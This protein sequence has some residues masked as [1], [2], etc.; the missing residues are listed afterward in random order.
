MGFDMDATEASEISQAVLPA[1]IREATNRFVDRLPDPTPLQ[2]S[3]R[4]GCWL[5]RDDSGE[6]GTHKS[7]GLMV[8]MAVEMH[9]GCS[10]FSISS[11][12]NAALAAAKWSRRL[13]A[14]CLC[15]LSHK[16]PTAKIEAVARTGAPTVVTSKPKNLSRYA[17][18]YAGLI[19]L[20]PSRHPLGAMGYRSLAA[21][22]CVAR[23]RVSSVFC[24]CNSG[25][26][27]AG[28]REG[29]DLLLAAGSIDSVPQLHAVQC[30]ERGDLPTRLG[31]EVRLEQ[32]PVAGA[33]GARV[34]PDLETVASA[35][36]DTGGSAWM[37][38]NDEVSVAETAML[39]EGIECA[40]ESSA[41]FA[42][43]QR[44]RTRWKVGDNPVVVVAGR[45]FHGGEADLRTIPGVHL[46]SDYRQ[47][48]ELLCELG[49]ERPSET[50]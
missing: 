8:Q 11:S 27:I 40:I 28:L 6:M 22:L 2:F 37:V 33:L 41:A 13:G 24:F 9:A 4:L 43:L 47:V 35:I 18:R 45:R 25:L 48:R 38:T 7:R 39:G 19:D 30:S 32:A 1:S 44:A 20:R 50:R 12:G 17:A 5:K 34:P 10:G 31:A 29:F 26:T 49:L 46:M 16:T 21:E 3:S 15:F 14:T 42:G 23:T 36:T